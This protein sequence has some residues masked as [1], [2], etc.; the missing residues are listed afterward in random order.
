[1]RKFVFCDC[2]FVPIKFHGN[3]PIETS[4]FRL[5][6]AIRMML[7]DITNQNNILLNC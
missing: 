7:Q 5:F 1:M 4:I 2:H 6:L 3:V